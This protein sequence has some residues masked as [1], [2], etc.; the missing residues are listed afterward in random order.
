MV[1]LPIHGQGGR[2]AAALL[3]TGGWAGGDGSE[4][5]EGGGAAAAVAAKAVQ[6][7]AADITELRRLAQVVGLSLVIGDPQQAAYLERL[8][9]LLVALLS[10][11]PPGLHDLV[12]SLLDALPSLLQ[13][14][15]SLS[16]QPLLACL[17][18]AGSSAALVFAPRRGAA[19]GSLGAAPVHSMGTGTGYLSPASNP[20]LSQL[21]SGVGP[22][23]LA[24]AGSPLQSGRL[25]TVAS[26]LA[27]QQ[28]Q[29]QGQGSESASS[30]HQRLLS[31][32]LANGGVVAGPPPPPS[33]PSPFARATSLGLVPSGVAASRVKAVRTALGHTLLQKLVGGG[34]VASGAVR[35]LSSGLIPVPSPR[36]GARLSAAGC[37]APAVDVADPA[38]AAAAPAYLVLTDASSA[39]LGKSGPDRD[40]LLAANLTG[41]NAVTALVLVAEPPPPP[42]WSA[43]TV[44]AAADQAVDGAAS[45]KSA[46][47]SLTQPMSPLALARW[48]SSALEDRG[49]A[50]PHGDGS[51]K[52]QADGSCPLPSVSGPLPPAANVTFAHSAAAAPFRLALYMVSPESVPAGVLE[53]VAAEL[54]ALTPLVFAAFRCAVTQSPGIAA[55]WWQLLSQCAAGPTTPIPSTAATPVKPRTVAPSPVV[56]MQR[57]AS[58]AGTVAAHEPGRSSAG[59]VRMEHFSPLPGLRRLKS[60]PP[61]PSLPSP[62]GGSP[63]GPEDAPS[64]RVLA[65][66]ALSPQALLGA[67]AVA[68]DAG[69]MAGAGRVGPGVRPHSQRA[70]VRSTRDSY[71]TSANGSFPCSYDE[72]MDMDGGAAPSMA[73]S[74]GPNQV[75]SGSGSASANLRRQAASAA[76]M[77]RSSW[78]PT[79]QLEDVS[80]PRPLELMVSS[81]RSRLTAVLAGGEGGEEARLASSQDLAAV[82]LREV[83]GRGGQGV[84]F[85]GYLHGLEAAIKVLEHVGRAPLDHDGAA[86]LL[87]DPQ[88]AREAAAAAQAAGA[89]P[90]GCG[91]TMEVEPVERQMEQ[92]RREAMEVAVMGQLSHPNIVQ[93]YAQ[94][95]EAAV[96]QPPTAPGSCMPPP[97]RLVPLDHPLL[98]GKMPSPTNSILCL[99]YCDAGTLL[100]AARRGDF[101][102]PGSCPREGPVWPSP[103]PLYTSLLEV[104]LA[105]RYLHA[106]RLVHCDLKP[107]NVLLKTN[108]RDPRGWTCKL[109]DLGCV[110]VMDELGPDGA[111]GFTCQSMYGTVQYMSPEF[112]C[113]DRLLNGAVDV[114]AFGIMMWELMH[115]K[116]A[117]NQVKRNALPALV[118]RHGMRPE[119]HPLA[120]PEYSTLAARCWAQQ[121]ECRPTAAHL[122]SEL[123]QLLA[124]ARTLEPMRAA[125]AARPERAKPSRAPVP[126][127]PPLP[128][129][130][131]APALTPDGATPGRRKTPP[132][133]PP[134]PHVLPSPLPPAARPD[135]GS[136]D[137]DTLLGI[138]DASSH[139]TGP[140][141]AA[142]RPQARP[143]GG[144]VV[145]VRAASTDARG[146]YFVMLP[147]GAAPELLQATQG[148]ERVAAEERP[149]ER[150]PGGGAAAVAPGAGS[151]AAE[152]PWHEMEGGEGCYSS[153]THVSVIS[154]I[155]AA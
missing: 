135:A 104:A 108:A 139:F 3:L 35:R 84:V 69:S 19:D 96:V 112:I 76:L 149:R 146:S 92:V 12:A 5:G 38:A 130:P 43:A 15:F 8:A 120:P 81:A 75:L 7:G 153:L 122:V 106:R 137:P 17:P 61:M 152:A 155:T 24:A 23:L 66:V 14:R 101:R 82:E 141:P 34:P 140:G 123:Q 72:L 142:A 124:T 103:I 48:K 11:R 117:Y 29:G 138:T 87:N 147:P 113:Q 125:E 119:F 27:A 151:G 45:L 134:H 57:A 109:S 47:A 133:A 88:D 86:M 78:C 145:P 30:K 55:E 16:M 102:R 74:F 116:V 89:P 9:S 44:A 4:G 68:V 39:S 114:Y 73:D 154:L 22:K 32:V 36:P 37:A 143:K 97:L 136:S 94:F 40:V 63:A 83:I 121:P 59:G 53:A 105:L 20:S 128:A 115:C 91:A 52:A 33:A 126:P 98:G 13:A 2:L 129:L 56:P 62:I 1:A 107:G 80:G 46:P 100:T 58:H 71:G 79:L 144:P 85:R 65:G 93:V 148:G 21:P 99:E 110:R 31:A 49:A 10:A 28:G 51:G 118:T 67:Q 25:P 111:S 26:F 90:P 77:R 127:L 6:L 150:S 95:S 70:C 18:A 132:P 131:P 42:A 54:V 64:P 41:A 50:A 60:P